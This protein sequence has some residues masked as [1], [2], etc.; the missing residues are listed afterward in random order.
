MLIK[1]LKSF[2]HYA[3][4]LFG[5]VVFRFPSRKIS[6]I[7]VTGTKG[8]STTVELLAWI[9]SQ[10]KKKTASLSSAFVRILAHEEENPTRNTMP[11]R[12]FIQR[13]LA[14]AAKQG[15]EFAIIEVT[16]QGVEQ[17][18]HRFIDFDAAL[19]TNLHP[20]HVEAH[21]SFEAYR[22]AK[23]RFFSD[24][25]KKSRKKEK[26]FFIYRNFA[27]KA[28]FERAAKGQKV[29]FFDES[30][31][32]KE[33]VS[34]WLRSEFNLKNASGA[35]A[36]AV[37]FGVSREGAVSALR[38]FKGMPGRSEFVFGKTKEGRARTA[39]I[40]YALTP[41][42]LES[43]Y[44]FL[45]A[46][47]K[48]KGR[49]VA[50]FGSAGGGRDAWKRPVLGRVAE[51]Y[52]KKIYL[53]TDDP[54]DE[55]PKDIAREIASGVSNKEKIEIEVDRAKAIEAAIKEAQEDDIVA[56]TGI[57]SQRYMYGKRGKKIPWSERAAVEKAFSI[58][59]E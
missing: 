31:L 13:F 19:I 40:D 26:K 44:K 50:V 27:D 52:C 29:V 55:D 41:E 32:K 39:V 1:K 4:S 22:A 14:R 59:N 58:F 42:S 51:K 33:E 18:R 34:E 10:N 54:Y 17:F 5:A 43:L 56:I 6:V 11:G 37:E 46:K 38:T 9:L 23:V 2:Y 35:L 30:L 28:Y 24:T 8:K 20:E 57:G 36:A 49:L 12:F 25:A 21:G 16:S 7:G 48:P 3:L 15:A 53:T 47:L 45:T